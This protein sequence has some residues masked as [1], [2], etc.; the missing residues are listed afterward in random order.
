MPRSRGRRVTTRAANEVP[1]WQ[2]QVAE[3]VHRPEKLLCLAWSAAPFN[4]IWSS[5][6]T[7]DVA[8]TVESHCMITH[9]AAA[10][11]SATDPT[12]LAVDFSFPL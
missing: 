1:R 7:E 3:V 2:R 8:D 12:I 11:S 10:T 9:S 4:N 5:P 6:S